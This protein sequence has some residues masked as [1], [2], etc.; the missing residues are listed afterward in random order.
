[1]LGISTG[2]VVTTGVDKPMHPC[3]LGIITGPVVTTGVLMTSPCMLGI[4]TGLVGDY[5]KLMT[6]VCGVPVGATAQQYSRNENDVWCDLLGCDCVAV[7]P[8]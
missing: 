2:P 5:S 3:M 8:E 7:Q 4:S 1:M 6:R